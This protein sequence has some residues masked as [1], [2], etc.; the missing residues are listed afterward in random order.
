MRKT[1]SYSKHFDR[2]KNQLSDYHKEAKLKFQTDHPKAVAWLEKRNL[3]IGAVRR[4]SQQL[5]TGATLSS[6]LLFGTGQSNPGLPEG[7]AQQKMAQVYLTSSGQ[8]RD[9][10]ATELKKILPLRIGH[11]DLQDQPQIEQMI[12]E[13]LGIKVKFTLEGQQL[14]DSLGYMGAEQHLPRFPGDSVRLHDEWQA[15]GIT[16]GLG[17]WGYFTNSSSNLTADL[18]LKEKYYVAV[19]TLYLPTWQKDLK[20]L[21][22]WYKYRKVLVVNP[23]TGAVV[24]AVIADSGPASFTGK[25]FGGSPE[26]MEALDLHKGPRKGKVLLLFVDDP[27]NQVPLGPVKGPLTV[28]EPE[29]V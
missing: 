7:T 10:L 23:Q 22:D 13:A 11:P 12:Q 3:D 16:P 27:N 24:V 19:Q 17:A 29:E 15:S 28:P 14:N 26:V 25:Q 8:I 21:R 9:K 6:L 2:L 18:E 1:Q 20:F 4:H 5:L